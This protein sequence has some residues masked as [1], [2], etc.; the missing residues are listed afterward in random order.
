MKTLIFKI[1]H[2][3]L[4]LKINLHQV[5]GLKFTNLVKHSNA[6]KVKNINGNSLGDIETCRDVSA[7]TRPIQNC[8]TTLIPSILQ[9]PRPGVRSSSVVTA[10]FSFIKN[11]WIAWH[12][13]NDVEGLFTPHL[14]LYH[15]VRRKTRLKLSPSTN[16]LPGWLNCKKIFPK[17]TVPV[18]SLCSGAIISPLLFVSFGSEFLPFLYAGMALAIVAFTWQCT[19]STSL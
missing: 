2:L 1:I 13:A 12:A 11:Q 16:S 17:Y 8:Y 5:V 14:P 6:A 15:Q 18:S 10:A 19:K 3:S 9:N 7:W 4:L